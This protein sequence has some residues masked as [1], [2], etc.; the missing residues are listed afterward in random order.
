MFT[1][2]LIKKTTL[3]LATALL[4][5]CAIK[6][7][8][9][10]EVFDISYSLTEGGYRLELDSTNLFKGVRLDVNTTA[11][12]RYEVS[13]RL[14]QPMEN[15][16]KPGVFID[17]NFVMR[18]LRGSNRTGNFRISSSSVPVRMDDA[19]YVSD[20]NGSA[21]SFTLFFGI[22]RFQ[23]VSPGVYTGRLSF[24]LKPISSSLA[25]VIKILE[26]Q[27]TVRANDSGK[28][29]VEISTATGLKNILLDPQKQDAR[30][31]QVLV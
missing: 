9:S 13:L 6:P 21:D 18:G 22:E 23:D 28:P 25:P 5:C 15:R 27:I 29:L 16:E 12:T 31:A 1:Y 2:M 4:V 17:N 30:S 10:A 14:I 19:L 24:T 11:A 3:C 7:L 8:Y 20:A 26:A